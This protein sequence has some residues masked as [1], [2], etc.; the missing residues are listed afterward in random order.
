MNRLPCQ[1]KVTVRQV[2]FQWWMKTN[3][4][5]KMRQQ[6]SGNYVGRE[7]GGPNGFLVTS[8]NM[9]TQH[10][11]QHSPA[12]RPKPL[13]QQG[14]SCFLTVPNSNPLSFNEGESSR[15]K[16]EQFALQR[17]HHIFSSDAQSLDLNLSFT[18]P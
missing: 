8:P 12:L 18:Q 15:E 4:Y 10:I 16:V 5:I 13:D 7:R 17:I 9:S 14:Q 6:V 11:G 2:I 1:C 3:A